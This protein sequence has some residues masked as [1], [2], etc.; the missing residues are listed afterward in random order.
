MV[1][2]TTRVTGL[3]DKQ[4]VD[5]HHNFDTGDDAHDRA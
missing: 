5:H 2:A 1:A 3:V 4:R